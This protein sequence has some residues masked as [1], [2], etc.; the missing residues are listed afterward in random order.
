M[1]LV[2]GK[3]SASDE[4]WKGELKVQLQGQFT[5]ALSQAETEAGYDLRAGLNLVFL[6]EHVKKR[7]GVK[8]V[9]KTYETE[10]AKARDIAGLLQGATPLSPSD[11]L[12]I[13]P[14]V[15]TT[16][17]LRAAAAIGTIDTNFEEAEAVWPFPPPPPNLGGNESNHII[18]VKYRCTRSN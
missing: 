17:V 4:F 2:F 16:R 13:E 1:N 9:E 8:M 11:I 7:C 12:E 10:E 14:T 15:K 6:F 18:T 5:G 3:S